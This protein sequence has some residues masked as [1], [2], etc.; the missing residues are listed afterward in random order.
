MKSTVLLD[1][2]ARPEANNYG[3]TKVHPDFVGGYSDDRSRH[4]SLSLS[5][6][7]DALPQKAA[8][9]SE[10][11]WRRRT[12]KFLWILPLVHSEFWIAAGFSLLQSF[13]PAMANDKGLEADEYSYVYSSYKIAMMLGAILAERIIRLD[14]LE[15]PNVTRDNSSFPAT[16]R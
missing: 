1:R 4:G 16:E 8:E 12:R 2:D 15:S 13:Y 3:A 10:T 7:V 9:Q 14:D 6:M 11:K 5:K